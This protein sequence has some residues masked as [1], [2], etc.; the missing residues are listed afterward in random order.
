MTICP[1]CD[2]NNPLATATDGDGCPQEGDILICIECL[3]VGI[4]KDN[5]SEKVDVAQL[6]AYVG[7]EI[8]RCKEAMLRIKAKGK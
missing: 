8:E 1:Y 6:P 7:D 2:K 3:G 5:K 4:M